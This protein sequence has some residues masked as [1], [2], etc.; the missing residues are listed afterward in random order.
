MLVSTLLL[1]LVCA[2]ASPAAAD[3]AAVI[4]R[5]GELFETGRPDSAAVLLF[6]V[7]DAV[8]GGNEKVRALYYLAMSMERLGRLAEEIS[9]LIMAREAG[10]DAPFADDVRYAYAKILLDTGN[11]DDCVGVVDEFRKLFESSPLMPD[12]LF[13][14]GSASLQKGEFRRAFNAFNEISKNYPESAAAVESIMKEGVCL[15]H[16][17]LINGAIERFEQYLVKSPNGRNT[18]DALYFAGLACDLGNQPGQ[19][20]QYFRRLVL[21]YPSYPDI[22]DVY[23]KLGVR[24]YQTGKYAEAENMFENYAFNA[25]ES[26]E[27]RDEALL[28]LERIK[29]RTGVYA[30]EADIGENFIVKYPESPLTP[31]LIFDLARYYRTMGKPDDA[32]EK[33]R[34]LMNNP[35]YTAH[36]DSAAFLIA[37]TL[38]AA[39]E[40]DRAVSFLTATAHDRP[41]TETS[42]KMY[43]KLGSLHEEWEQYNAAIA[44]YDSSLSVGVSREVSF[45]SLWGIGR[46]FKTLN[47]WY[48]ASVTLERV[49]AEYPRHQALT[50]V[51][52]A[53]ADIYFLQGRIRDSIAVAE[54]A[55]VR[56]KGTRKH[57]IF[58][59]IAELYEEIDEKHALSLYSQIF[60]DEDNLPEHRTKALLQYG[61]LSMRTGDRLSAL[62]AYAR[63]LSGDADSVAVRKARSRISRIEGGT[64]DGAILRD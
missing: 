21:E 12:M 48:E 28:N 54:K 53:L 50:E 52:M 38:G 34:I 20:V 16:L 41:A 58:L 27:R 25:S 14:A 15:F 46:I 29:F 47:R 13:L 3:T 45:Q 23:Y 17:D 64:P 22:M 60:K 39:G 44:W 11:L 63:I 55:A 4:D 9:Y 10:I 43:A 26:D 24:L 51:Y 35:L 1:I 18:G 32:I 59:F 49:I 40:R 6:D 57:E 61:D 7:L 62:N 37:D 30:S 56:A 19:A 42:Q 8:D 36:T 5:A 2:A 31:G 33:Y